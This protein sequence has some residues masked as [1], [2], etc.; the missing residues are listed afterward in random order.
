MITTTR[1]GNIRTPVTTIA[2]LEPVMIA[3]KNTMTAR[4]SPV[5]A[6]GRAA[7]HL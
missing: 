4:P 7:R 3:P 6:G 2:F 5:P 1:K